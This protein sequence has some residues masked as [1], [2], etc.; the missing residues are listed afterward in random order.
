LPAVSEIIAEIERIVRVYPAW[1]I[2]VTGDPD[3]L[4]KEHNHIAWH[5]WD[6]ALESTARTV[7]VYFLKKGM[8]SAPGSGVNLRYVYIF[9]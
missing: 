6:A 4:R 2:G 1:S 9:M 5:C 8:N 3:R 7:E